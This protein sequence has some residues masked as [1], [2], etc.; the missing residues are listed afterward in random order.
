MIAKAIFSV[1]RG[2]GTGRV[3]RNARLTISC[4]AA[5]RNFFWE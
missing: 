1:S 2:L 5:L 4:R 3:G